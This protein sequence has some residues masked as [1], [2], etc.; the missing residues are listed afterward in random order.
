[1]NREDRE[2]RRN[3]EGYLDLTAYH[4]IKKAD[5]DIV[6]DEPKPKKKRKRKGPVKT[7]GPY[8]TWNPTSLKIYINR[9]IKILEQLGVEL[10]DHE[11]AHLKSLTNE[12]AV[13]LYAHDLI[14]GKD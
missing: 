9:K 1:M 14:I 3:G 6:V 10:D 4:A 12:I 2:L 8:D 11:I 7:K 5:K 13:D